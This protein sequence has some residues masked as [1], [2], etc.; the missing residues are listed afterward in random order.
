MPSNYCYPLSRVEDA[1]E[2]GRK[3]GNLARV[4]RLGY[5]VP[6]TMVVNRDA[7]RRFISANKLQGLIEECFSSG[8]GSQMAVAFES[9]VNAVHEAVVPEELR[10]EIREVV[11]G[12]L[13]ESPYGLAI[14]SSAVLEDS[15]RASFAGVFESFL[16]IVSPDEALEKIL[17]CWCSA[18]LGKARDVQELQA[19]SLKRQRQQE[20]EI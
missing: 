12:L 9:V 1:A 6:G 15:Q 10:G 13:R 16:G 7:L 3:A 11:E 4:A 20:Q 19:E 8:H 2:F 14:R 17:S 5:R 18:W